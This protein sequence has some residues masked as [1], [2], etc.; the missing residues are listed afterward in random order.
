[1]DKSAPSSPVTARGSDIAMSSSQTIKNRE[2]G[3]R[4][5]NP[6]TQEMKDAEG[7]SRMDIDKVSFSFV[8]SINSPNFE[9]SVVP[10]KDF[11]RFQNRKLFV[12]KFASWFSSNLFIHILH[13]TFSFVVKTKSRIFSCALI[14]LDIPIDGTFL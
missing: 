11:I 4:E 7:D 8:F 2:A 10:F 5:G 14:Q 13:F 6:F 1:V 3:L 12:C 9:F